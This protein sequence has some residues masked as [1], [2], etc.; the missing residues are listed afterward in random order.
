VAIAAAQKEADAASA[1]LATAQSALDATKATLAGLQ[2]YSASLRGL[3][4]SPATN[5]ATSRAAFEA[6]ATRARAGD[7]TAIAGLQG[8][9]QTYLEQSRAY[10]ASGVGYQRDVASVQTVVDEVAAT[11]Q[12]AADVQQLIVD[13]L[14]EQ[15]RVA[16][17]SLLSLQNAEFVRQLTN[18]EAYYAAAY[19]AALAQADSAAIAAAIA[20]LQAWQEAADDRALDAMLGISG[21]LTTGS[22][23]Q[24]DMLE[25]IR[26]LL[27][28]EVAPPPISIIPPVPYIEPPSG[29]DA[30]AA[31]AERTAAEKVAADAAAALLDVTVAAAAE[32]SVALG[33][34]EAAL[35]K[36]ATETRRTAEALAV[37]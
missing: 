16:A 26:V 27:G 11:Y 1:R 24:L 17:A 35:L 34:L 28:G 5:L 29:A 19:T 4:G 9:G 12:A 2:A 32:Y 10:N 7:Q 13:A 31:A 25:Q 8:A 23:A 37:A 18:A 6:L 21:T 20:G 36:V 30:K 14:A 22:A 3:T 33:K 15:N